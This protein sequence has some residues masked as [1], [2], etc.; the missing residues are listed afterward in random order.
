MN[1]LKL[2]QPSVI[3]PTLCGL[4]LGAIATALILNSDQK[5]D[6][7]RSQEEEILYWVAPM[8]ANYRR[9]GPGKSPMGMDLIPIYKNQSRSTSDA[10]PGSI[11]ISPQVMNNLG[12][13]TATAEK[14]MFKDEIRTVGYVKYDE[15]KLIHI[16][17]RVSGWVDKLYVKASG[18]PI[19]KNSPLYSLYSPELVNAQE[20]Y[21]LA[22][23]R[24]NTR[25]IKATEDRL[26]ALQIPP[27]F[28]KELRSS[29]TIQQSVTFYSPQNGVIDNL[30]IREGFYV[31]PGTTL[32]SV[33][34]LDTV[35]VEAEVFERQSALVKVG[36]KVS[37]TLDY[38][39]DELWQGKVDY[40]YPTLDSVTR[41][42][43]LRIK[44]DNPNQKLLPNMFS[45]IVIYTEI[46]HEVL[47]VP[48]E[49][50]IRT[51]DQDRVVLVL[52][53]G[54]FKSISVKIGRTNNSFIEIVEGLKEGDEIVS[55]AQFLLDSESSITSDFMRMQAVDE[56]PKQVWVDGVVK[57]IHSENRTIR[58]NHSPIAAWGMG[59]MTMNFTLADDIN[60]LT[61]EQEQ[62]IQI[63]IQD[64]GNGPY[65]IV[66]LLKDTA[67]KKK[68]GKNFQLAT[69][70][71]KVNSIDWNRRLANISRG[72]IVKW[73]RPPAT[74]EFL[75]SE[76][77]DPKCLAKGDQLLFT[78]EIRR[79]IF[80]VTE[81]SESTNANFSET[82]CSRPE[83]NREVE[84]K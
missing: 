53:E 15:N 6:S 63:K 70:R 36:S 48:R 25:L 84:Q 40:I 57:E 62:A 81:I 74:I 17:P 1:S 71:G 20:E 56:L 45:Q 29:R 28:M 7:S 31:Q 14:K 58:V 43:R 52:G 8:D 54:M 69:V 9:D 82:Q 4:V 64:P 51:G 60:I 13:R 59:S 39:P 32:F 26:R 19:R 23:N 55:S 76:A 65:E 2:I 80:L 24:N 34:A 33:G 10:G 66:E 79:G 16:H 68:A 18:D 49:S 46:D 75:I 11:T 72:P 38:L 73:Q 47:L 44:F 35:W 42:V 22:L 83:A 67:G 50:V 78:F 41:T 27:S 5:S 3:L 21:V 12:V 30:N 37:M 61:L 77:I